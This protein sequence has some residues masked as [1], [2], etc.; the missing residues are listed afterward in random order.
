LQSCGAA[1]MPCAEDTDAAATSRAPIKATSKLAAKSKRLGSLIRMARLAGV[2]GGD[3]KNLG[4]RGRRT[5]S[6]DII[7]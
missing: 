1:V 6:S 2:T 5:A 7:L 4:G 3:L